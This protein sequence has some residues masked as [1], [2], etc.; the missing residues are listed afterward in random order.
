M[1]TNPHA[2]P[3]SCHAQYTIYSPHKPMTLEERARQ[4]WRGHPQDVTNL[5]FETREAFYLAHL[6]AAHVEGWSSGGAAMQKEII[7]TMHLYAG[8]PADSTLVAMVS[9]VI[10][11]PPHNPEVM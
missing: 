8:E 3:S 11:P 2:W 6:T 9:D 4:M 10:V 1:N 7:T 5:G